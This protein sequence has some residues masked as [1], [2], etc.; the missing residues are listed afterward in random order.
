[1]KEEVILKIFG[2]GQITIP[3]RWRDFLK[4]D[5]LK[6]V[7][8][9]LDQKISV[10]PV[11]MVELE[12]TKWISAE[13]LKKSLDDANYSDAFKNELV[14]GYKKSQFYKSGLK[15]KN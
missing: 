15:N 3:K 11:K 13:E 8:D 10:K 5:T 2:T 14:A 4:A 7:F 6:A 12:D 1:M 9:P